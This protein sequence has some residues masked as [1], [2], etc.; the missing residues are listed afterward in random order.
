MLEKTNIRFLI[1]GNYRTGSTLLMKGLS[2]HP[3]VA[4]TGEIFNVGAISRNLS[5]LDDPVA[6]MSQVFQA[7]ANASVR[8]AGFKLMYCQATPAELTTEYWGEDAPKNILGSVTAINSHIASKRDD[9]LQKLS[10]VWDALLG[11]KQLRVIHLTRECLLASF[12][13]F[14]LA[15]RE[16]LWFGNGYR[17]ESIA[18]DAVRLSAWFEFNDEMARHCNASFVAHP[19]L[20]VKYEELQASFLVTMSRVSRFIGVSPMTVEQPIARQ[21]SGTLR[22]AIANYEELRQ[23]FAH[24]KWREQ[25]EMEE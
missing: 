7:G 2:Q 3:E 13:S 10:G 8:A 1:L 6:H 20:S 18:L 5:V 19:L 12:L 4:I 17:N 25:F 16:N 23:E 11:D 15:L 22:S 14:R 21:R 9:Y 24:T